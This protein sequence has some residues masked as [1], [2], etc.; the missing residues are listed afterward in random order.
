M[1]MAFVPMALPWAGGLLPLRGG[2]RSVCEQILF[3]VFD[4]VESQEFCVFFTECAF[5][6]MLF[7][8]FDVLPRLVDKR[9]AHRECAITALPCE[10][11]IMCADGFEPPAA[12]SLHFF[13]DVGYCLGPRQ[14]EEYVDMVSDAAYLYQCAA[15]DVDQLSDI[16]MDAFQILFANLGTCCLDMEYQIL[17]HIHLEFR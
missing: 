12:V 3:V 8:S 7:L 5:C 6:V 2:G 1:A 11:F 15:C 14:Q 13:D 17:P 10:V 9:L 16:R 4:L